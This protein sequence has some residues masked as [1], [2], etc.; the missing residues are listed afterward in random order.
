MLIQTN[1]LNNSST[2]LRYFTSEEDAKSTLDLES[3]SHRMV[4]L[5]ETTLILAQEVFHKCTHFL[6]LV[7]YLKN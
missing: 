2:L 3:F 7:K 4:H 5:R 6:C 1:Y